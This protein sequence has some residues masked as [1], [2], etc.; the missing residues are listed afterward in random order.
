MSPEPFV[1]CAKALLAKRT[2]KGYEDEND[3]CSKNIIFEL[4]TIYFVMLAL[5]STKYID[6]YTIVL[7]ILESN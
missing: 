4:T 6:C 7:K 2:K 3:N 5:V 1:S